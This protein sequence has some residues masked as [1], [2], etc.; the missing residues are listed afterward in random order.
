MQ[1]NVVL[2][3]AM[4]ASLR[5]LLADKFVELVTTYNRDC[6]LRIDAIRSALLTPEFA[7]INH[8][9]HGIKGSSRNIGANSL[10]DLCEK[11]E[12]KARAQDSAGMEQLFTAIEQDFAVVSAELTQLIA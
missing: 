11:L 8:E 4:L 1:N 10:A 3:T 5:E 6:A 9:A 7:V 2:D 12:Q